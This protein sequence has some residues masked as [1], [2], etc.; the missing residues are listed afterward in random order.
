MQKFGIG[1]PATRF[2][3]NRLLSGKGQY[4]EDIELD[5]QTFAIDV[6]LLPVAYFEF[7]IF[8]F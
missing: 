5:N 1:Q 7:S 8:N 2:E 3:D 4:V 6:F